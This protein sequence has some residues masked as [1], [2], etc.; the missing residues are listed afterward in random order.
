M[1]LSSQVD[2]LLGKHRGFAPAAY[3]AKVRLG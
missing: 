1:F 3:F 2:P